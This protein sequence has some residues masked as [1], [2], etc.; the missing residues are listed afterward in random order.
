MKRFFLFLGLGGTGLLA[1]TAVS[2]AARHST[3]ITNPAIVAAGATCKGQGLKPG[4]DAFRACVQNLV[5]TNTTK[6][7]T[8][9]ASTNPAAV[10][11]GKTCKGQGLTPGSDAFK[12]CVHNIVSPNKTTTN[13]HPNLQAAQ[14]ACKAQGLT[15]GSDAFKQCVKQ[16]LGK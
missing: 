5:K 10:A 15:P 14:Q 11:A 13:A 1:A 4:S 3:T 6:T 9:P 8:N 12:T 7:D 2:M 16:Q